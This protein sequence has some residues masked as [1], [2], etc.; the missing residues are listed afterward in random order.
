MS[1]GY[2]SDLLTASRPETLRRLVLGPGILLS[3]LWPGPDLTREALDR[4]IGAAM[5]SG[6]GVLGVTGETA[7]EAV[8]RFAEVRLA[9]QTGPVRGT[10]VPVW[11]EAVLT[12]TLLEIGPDNLRRLLALCP[13][14]RPADG[15]ALRLCPAETSGGEED[16]LC[17]IGDRAD[18]GRIAVGLRHPLS[19]GSPRLVFRPDGPAAVSFRFAAQE[20][21]ETG[22]APFC[23]WTEDTANDLQ[24]RS[25]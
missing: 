11:T 23:V 7:F 2:G 22:E 18:G 15:T 21:P 14:P 9:G 19:A 3:G 25:L 16:C 4:R 8:R 13:A 24:E 12:G 10:R 1:D 17:W 20:D 6:E 5:A